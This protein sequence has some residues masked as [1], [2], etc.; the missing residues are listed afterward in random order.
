MLGDQVKVINELAV[1]GCMP[2]LTFLM[3]LSPEIGKSR[4]DVH[5]QDRLEQEKLEFHNRVYE[6]YRQIAA[7]A[8]QRFVKIDASADAESIRE[9]IL[10]HI[11][12]LLEE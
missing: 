9:N 1:D 5:S 12:K 8:P 11:K 2:D 7:R 4:I 3:E 10:F 6:G